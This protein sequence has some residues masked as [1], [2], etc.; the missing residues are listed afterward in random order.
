MNVLC[1]SALFTFVIYRSFAK[2]FKLLWENE[3]YE[4]TLAAQVEEMAATNKALETANATK[5]KFFSIIAHDLRGPAGSLSVLFNDMISSGADLED[6]ILTEVKKTTKNLHNLLEELLSWAR[7]QQGRIDVK[8]QNFSVKKVTD[9]C[10]SLLDGNAKRKGVQK[11]NAI[12]EKVFLYADPALT[13]TVIRNLISNAIKYTSKDDAITV[14]SVPKKGTVEVSVQDTGVGIKPEVLAKLFKI[15]E[16]VESSLG[17]S[18]EAGTGLGLILCKEFVEKNGGEIGVESEP[19]KGSRFWFVLPAGESTILTAGEITTADQK[20]LSHLKI[21]LV[22][23]NDLHRKTSSLV[24]NEIGVAFETAADGFEAIEMVSN[25]KYDAIL[26]EID[27][28]RMNGIEAS[29]IITAN[30]HA[31]QIVALSSY[32]KSELEEL[33]H[34]FPFEGYL[35][36]PLAKSM[37]IE[38]LTRL[39]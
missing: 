18:N 26:M 27:M 8:P 3:Q 12:S 16:K 30:A 36:K 17:T 13:T 6:E 15:G 4:I 21:L 20:S 19:G 31:P 7:S 34:S 25:N 24:L 2:Q 9:E 22:E 38:I 10:I 33:S 5:N 32:S 28:P 11:I 29:K 23:D 37:L 39:K 35:N 1:I 14:G